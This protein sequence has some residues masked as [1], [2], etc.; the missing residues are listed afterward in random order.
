MRALHFAV[1]CLLTFPAWAGT[2][3]VTGKCEVKVVP[4]RA[5]LQ[6]QTEKTAGSVKAAGTDVTLR[7]EK[8]R[9]AIKQMNL[10]DVE[11]RTSQYNVA[12]HHEWSNNKNVFK[13]Y[14]ATLSLEVVTSEI[15][16]MGEVIAKAADNGLNSTNSFNTFLSL[17]KSQD[18]YLKCLDLAAVDARKKAD[19]L[20]K[21][22]GADIGDVDNIIE[23]TPV[24]H[25]PTPRMYE[26]ELTMAKSDAAPAPTIEVGTQLF[27]TT[28]NV[29]YKLK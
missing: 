15:E 12:P 19:R 14:T 5:S 21:K 3:S 27:S 9:E 6:L 24:M 13:G 25:A 26:A 16:R 10:K 29:S 8:V 11:L 7:I 23:S 18:E 4:D 20:A 1:L 17:E 22:L 28:I 2:I